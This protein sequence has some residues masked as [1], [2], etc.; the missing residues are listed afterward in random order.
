VEKELLRALEK[1]EE[2]A[3]EMPDQDEAEK[4]RSNLNRIA[5]DLRK[6][7]SSLVATRN[8]LWEKNQ[9]DLDAAV[10]NLEVEKRALNERAELDLVKQLRDFYTKRLNSA[11]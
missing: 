2:L 5:E 7:K 11:K 10:M 8:L 9:K 4:V 6:F 3:E 1:E